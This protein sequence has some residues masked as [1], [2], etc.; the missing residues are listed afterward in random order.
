MDYQHIRGSPFPVAVKLPIEKLGT[1]ILTVGVKG[2]RGIV[3]NQRGEVVLAEENGNCVSIFSSSGV[4][5]QSF[6]TSQGQF[7]NPHGVAVD[8]G[9]SSRCLVS[10]TAFRNS[11]QKASFSHAH[12]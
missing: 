11:Q 8:G 7:I 1:P 10:T 6:G 12:Q 3:F 2:P 9:A 4:K 5:L